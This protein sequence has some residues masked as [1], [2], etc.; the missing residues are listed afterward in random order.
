MSPLR[1]YLASLPLMGRLIGEM[2]TGGS[3]DPYPSVRL[4]ADIE[5]YHARRP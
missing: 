5:R 4:L 2:F 3:D 1:W